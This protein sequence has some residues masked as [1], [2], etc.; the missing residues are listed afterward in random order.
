MTIST[1]FVKIKNKTFALQTDS[2]ENVYIFE[3]ML[4]AWETTSSIKLD[5]SL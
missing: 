4:N 3:L 1:V 5:I 2:Y